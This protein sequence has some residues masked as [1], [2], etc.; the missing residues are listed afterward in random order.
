MTIDPWL[1][2]ALVPVTDMNQLVGCLACGNVFLRGLEA[3]HQADHD[4]MHDTNPVRKLRPSKG[5]K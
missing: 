4:W 3:T 2:G 1:A 5:T